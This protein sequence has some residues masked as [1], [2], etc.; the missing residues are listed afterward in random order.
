[1]YIQRKENKRLKNRDSHEF[2][3]NDHKLFNKLRANEVIEIPDKLAK[4]ILSWFGDAIEEVKN[5]VKKNNKEEVET[6]D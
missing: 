4:G 5:V 2:F 3:K 1:M 6:G